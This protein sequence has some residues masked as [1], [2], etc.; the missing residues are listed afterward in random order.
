MK[1]LIYSNK[2]MRLIFKLCELGES[3][4]EKIKTA[5]DIQYENKHKSDSCASKEFITQ[6]KRSKISLVVSVL[7]LVVAVFSLISYSLFL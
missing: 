6:N 7:M 4:W 1:G 3:D 5:T 2:D